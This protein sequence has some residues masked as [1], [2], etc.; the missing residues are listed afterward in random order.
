MKRLSLILFSI[1]FFGLAFALPGY[2]DSGRGAD[3]NQHHRGQ[4]AITNPDTN[5]ISHDD[6]TEFSG[7]IEYKSNTYW[8]I[9]GT[10]VQIDA[11]TEIKEDHGPA[12]VGA[13]VEVKARKQSDGSLYAKKIEV[14]EH[15]GTPGPTETPEPTE[16]PDPT[17]TPHPTE[18]PDPTQTPAAG[19]HV[20][21]RGVIESQNGNIWM[22][23]GTAVTVDSNTRIEEEHG[24]AVVGATVDVEALRQ[25]DGSLWAKK[26]EVKEQDDDHHGRE[27]EFQG[28]IQA[29][30]GSRWTIA[31]RD[32]MVD[33]NTEMDEREGRADV[34]AYVE[35][36][37]RENN[38]GSLNARRIRVRSHEDDQPRVD[39]EGRIQ[40]MN[41]D[42]WHVE[43]RM[44]RVDA[45][46]R[47][48]TE[49][50]P[51]QVGAFVEVR[52][53]QQTDGSLWAERIKTKKQNDPG[54][55]VEFSGMIETMTANHWTVGGFDVVLDA[56]TMID[57]RDGVA[58]VGAGAEVDATRQADGQLYANRVRIKDDVPDGA[59][60]EF[61]GPIEAMSA[62]MWTVAGFD[63]V[64]DDGTSFEHLERA[65]LGVSA[66]V[67][68]RRMADGSLLAI[69]IDVKG[70][71]FEQQREMEWKGR[72]ERF[73]AHNWTVAGRTVMLDA[74]TLVI[75]QPVVG[76][77]V[78]VKARQQ[79]D[80]SLMASRLEVQRIQE[81]TEFMG[82]V[83]SMDMN[84]WMIGGR[85]V[86]VDARTVFDER[87]GPIGLGVMVEVKARR[88]ADGSWLAIRI[89]SED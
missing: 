4:A 39:W 46:T 51:M 55:S 33:G 25:A 34:G 61:R 60:I 16:T 8:I 65:A 89:K 20:E 2:A 3:H 76:A 67:K 57:Q 35:V 21:F 12:E 74:N 70:N 15:H 24:Q 13:F 14:K 42:M 59:K 88:M 32:V 78:E 75:G 54:S 66:E 23:S 41:G 53:R 49:H 19:E 56:N 48:E 84:A 62:N 30:N 52:A 72:L 18:T 71:E 69:K 40:A 28:R 43:G 1:L 64:V 58:R 73:D 44:V 6:E 81:R 68:A 27:V 87:H 26:I 31:G 7:Y 80:G 29:K 37:A 86:Q 82:V 11:H 77:M 63:L 45:R 83:Q 22:I 9:S 47:L 36:K 17:G 85:T 79:F 38:D 50:G 10:T 5:A